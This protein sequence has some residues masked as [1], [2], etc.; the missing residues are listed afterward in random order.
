MTIKQILLLSVSVLLAYIV[1]ASC[2]KENDG[3]TRQTKVTTLKASVSAT[4][5]ATKTQHE[6]S[7][8][9]LKV[10]WSKGDEIAVSDG[11]ELFK[12]SQTGEISDD[13][14]S[15]LF[16]SES[17]VSFGEG[18]IISVYPYT[19][20]LTYDLSTQT[21]K[22]D[23]LFQTDLLL[24]R[25][26][27][28]ATSV[29]DLAF[30]PLCAVIRFP[31]DTLVTDE[32][33]TGEMKMTI[34][35]ENVGG[36]ITISKTGG[37]DVQKIDI[38]IPVTISKGRFAEDTYLV[39][40]PREKTGIY[41]YN[42]T[43][44]RDDEYSFNIENITTTSIYNA[45]SICNGFVVFEDENFKK[46]CIENFDLDED[47]EISYAEARKVKRMSF[48]TD[49]NHRNISS[50][51]GIEEFKNLTYLVCD[52][53][54][55][56]LASLD[57]SK[58]AKLDT[59]F[60]SGNELTFLD[61][62]NNSALIYLSCEHNSLTTLDLSNNSAL[63]VL[64]CDYNPLTS[65]DVSKNTA[66][67][68]L[69]CNHI[70]LTSLDVSKNTAL[71]ELSCYGNQLTSLDLSKNIALTTLICFSNHQLTNLDLSN[72]PTLAYLRCDDIP[73]TSLDVS[74]NPALTYLRCDGNGLISSLNLSNNPALIELSCSNDPLTSLDLSNNTALTKL[75][76][77]NT[78][79]TSLDLSKNLALTHL[80]CRWNQLISLDVSHNTALTW[81][82]CD[83]N[84]LTSL[85]V[86]NPALT[87]LRCSCNKLTSLDVSYNPALEYLNCYNNQ[88]TC[89]DVSNNTLLNELHAWPQSETLSTLVKKSGQNIYYYY[90]YNPSWSNV[91]SP[92]NYGTTI[93]EIDL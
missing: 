56:K 28:T 83:F 6:Y 52:G 46:Y 41:T 54:Y 92:S 80:D 43:T 88:L 24:G 33:F 93:V 18:E 25:A 17:T 63:T 66:L 1:V 10:R 27:V 76:C 39:F 47:G 77:Y 36:K 62:S 53:S 86:S 75:W 51:K 71:T 16:S 34:S 49:K 68:E 81:L 73:L 65:L 84:Q 48:C 67:T 61:L 59:L 91:I 85:Y 2:C 23:K 8:N 5:P 72:N 70:Q 14:H 31:K 42:L 7:D 89:L 82:S 90:H 29:E 78:Q 35:G 32:D 45:K 69:W 50:L 9:M 79:L 30:L 87:W 11:K 19:T 40:V 12:F 58:N 37:I 13:G 74:N 22:V 20:D 64:R 44:D 60:C 55:G 21:G 3:D 4:T 15:A 57:L 38:T 26:K